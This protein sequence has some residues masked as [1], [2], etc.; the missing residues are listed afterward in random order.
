ML[1]GG[2]KIVLNAIVAGQ[3]FVCGPGQN[4]RSATSI[5]LTALLP[6]SGMQCRFIEN[7]Y[8]S[9]RRLRSFKHS[10]RHLIN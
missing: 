5:W 8:K 10:C 1:C 4:H 7:Y 9:H 2:S 6:F 3:Q